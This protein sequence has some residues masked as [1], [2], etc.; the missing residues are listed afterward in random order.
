LTDVIVARQDGKVMEP[1]PF[2]FYASY[3]NLAATLVVCVI[4]SLLAALLVRYIHMKVTGR[5]VGYGK[6]YLSTVT[7]S[8]LI[9]ALQWSM[10]TVVEN[11]MATGMEAWTPMAIGSVLIVF[12]GL[13][14][15]ATFLRRMLGA[16]HGQAWKIS[17][18][19]LI[20]GA[21]IFAV[22][23]ALLFAACMIAWR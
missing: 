6:A 3:I 15:H 21:M 16:T 23:F 5:R 9:G 13:W 19:V 18:L 4:G 2:F 10:V 11:F 20:F 1:R 8:C 22:I 12:T 7:S 17:F 14:I